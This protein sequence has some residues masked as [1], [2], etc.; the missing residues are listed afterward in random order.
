VR[1]VSFPLRFAEPAAVCGEVFSCF[2]VFCFSRG[3]LLLL[4]SCRRL[5][6]FFF[7]AVCV[8]FTGFFRGT[9]H[10]GSAFVLFPQLA[11]ACLV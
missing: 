11:F 10:I 7:A 1:F 4:F 3:M 6:P 5:G 2:S 8:Y 9:T